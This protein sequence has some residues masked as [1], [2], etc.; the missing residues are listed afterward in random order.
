[1]LIDFTNCPVN[2]FRAYGGGNGAKIQ[3]TYCGKEYMLKFSGHKPG[4]GSYQNS[5]ISEYL[6]CHIFNSVG[7][8]SQD[9]LLGTYE[10]N[11]KRQ[12]VVACQDL[13]QCG[14]HLMEFSKLKNTCIDSSEE[15]NGTE[16][17]SI[18]DAIDEQKLIS[19]NHLRNFFWDSFIVDSLLGN[20]DRHNGN[21]GVLVNEELHQVK[22]APVYDCGSCLY[23]RA[24][25]EDYEKILEDPK[26]IEMRV[27]TF[28]TSAIKEN[29]IKINYFDFISSLKN[30]ECTKALRRITPRINMNNINKIVDETPGL[31]EVG[32]RFF[33]VM[34]QKR[35]ELILDFSLEK[36]RSQDR[37]KKINRD[38]SLG[39]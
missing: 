3:I 33:K 32:R 10:K 9:T 13:N 8:P 36:A 22:I 30:K 38:F 11:G 4:A 39:R 15:G 37:Q 12:F 17:S 34:L 7:I 27:F 16:L 20:F 35:K 2:L 28:P 31:S 6:G 18:L 21:W 1:M 23:P 29:G 25:E 19:P 14:F 26:E 24:T 5:H